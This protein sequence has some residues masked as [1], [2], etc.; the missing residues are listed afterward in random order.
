LNHLNNFTGKIIGVSK[1]LS[2]DPAILAMRV[3]GFAA[4]S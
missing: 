3:L 2:G 1:M 4:Y